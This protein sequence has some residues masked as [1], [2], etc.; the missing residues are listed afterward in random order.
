MLEHDIN[1][2]PSPTL[3]EGVFLPLSQQD[4]LDEGLVR[5]RDGIYLNIG[6]YD[7]MVNGSYRLTKWKKNQDKLKEGLIKT[8]EEDYVPLTNVE[9]VRKFQAPE[10][11]V[12]TAVYGDTNAPQ[13]QA[14]REF[15]DNVLARSAAG[16]AFIN[17]YYSGAGEKAANAIKTHL[18]TTIPL[19]RKC[20]DAV[21]SGYE[22]SRK[23]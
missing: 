8:T 23:R 20:L 18:P 5:C 17:F 15:R 7:I 11:F 3:K 4:K 21:V 10:C 13:V 16:K 14:L 1:N 19:I 22:H 12:A 2:D 9:K 6:S